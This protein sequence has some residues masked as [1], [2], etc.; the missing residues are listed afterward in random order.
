MLLLK[1]LPNKLSINIS[2]TG[3]SDAYGDIPKEDR[4]KYYACCLMVLWTVTSEY[5]IVRC[6]WF[7]S[8]W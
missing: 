6:D 5:I 8:K 3:I 2:F 7:Q 4:R 1:F